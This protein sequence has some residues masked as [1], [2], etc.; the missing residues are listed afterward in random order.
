[1]VGADG[2]SSERAGEGSSDF[3]DLEDQV[4]MFLDIS[5][6]LCEEILEVPEDTEDYEEWNPVQNIKEGIKNLQYALEIAKSPDFAEEHEEHVKHMAK[7]KAMKHEE[8]SSRRACVCGECEFCR[9]IMS[10]EQAQ[11][12][13]WYERGLTDWRNY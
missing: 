11:S 13:D 12:R 2:M 8:K 3:Q 7:Y 6:N 10:Q 5:K 1:M 9:K 4:H